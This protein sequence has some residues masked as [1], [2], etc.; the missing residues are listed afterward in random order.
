MNWGQGND[1]LY[2]GGSSFCWL[3]PGGCWW[4]TTS[5]HCGPSQQRAI[6][7]KREQLSVTNSQ[8]SQQ[9]GE[10]STS[11]VKGVGA[12]LQ[13]RPLLT[14]NERMM[15]HQLVSILSIYS[16]A[17]SFYRWQICTERN[18]VYRGEKSDVQ[19]PRSTVWPH[20]NF[21]SSA[22]LGVQL[23]SPALP[24]P[25]SQGSRHLSCPQ[26]LTHASLMAV[27]E[28]PFPSSLPSN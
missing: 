19:S 17:S 9:I 27:N 5:Y 7:W 16:T 22:R 4:C 8:H 14:H 21:V 15:A 13:E 23:T 28:I 18:L 10:G 2:A 6:R 25:C 20:T 24:L 12:G 11:P 26:A 1:I 3:W